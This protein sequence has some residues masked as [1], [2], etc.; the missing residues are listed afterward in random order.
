MNNVIT[1]YR[2]AISHVLEN[3]RRFANTL[4]CFN[5]DLLIDLPE[6][7]EQIIWYPKYRGSKKT[8][9]R[10][11]LNEAQWYMMKT[12][13][14]EFIIERGGKIWETMKDESGLINSNYGYQISSHHDIDDLADELIRNGRVDAWIVDTD[15]AKLKHDTVCNNVVRIHSNRD[16]LS[17]DVWTRSLDLTFGFPYDLAAA[18]ALAYMIASRA[19]LTSTISTVVFHVVNC[20][21]YERD[22]DCY[23]NATNDADIFDGVRFIDTPYAGCYVDDLADLITP[24]EG[25]APVPLFECEST[26]DHIIEYGDI[27]SDK[28]MHLVMSLTD[29]TNGDAVLREIS[30]LLSEYYAEPDTRKAMSVF[31]DQRKIVVWYQSGVWYHSPVFVS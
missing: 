10:Y 11:L 3:G 17:I 26:G 20:H 19:G 1:G 13:D 21:I 25:Y 2:Q 29:E 5:V 31:G 24:V 7:D 16:H 6:S 27:H 4:A 9:L 28:I 15:N 30:R 12:R 23:T 8:S 14:P 22:I 18:Q